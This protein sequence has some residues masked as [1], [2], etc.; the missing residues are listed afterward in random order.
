MLMITI[1]ES[2]REIHG[3]PIKKPA[4][5]KGRPRVLKPAQLGNSENC[6]VVLKNTGKAM[7]LCKRAIRQC[8]KA[9]NKQS[10]NIF[11]QFFLDVPHC[12]SIG[13]LAA[14]RSS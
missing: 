6:I 1:H 2:M 5:A 8:G 14:L 9:K 7:K 4:S 12:R 10:P 13:V 11:N 3:N